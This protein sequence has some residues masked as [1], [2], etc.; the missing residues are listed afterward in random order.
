[1]C[2]LSFRLTGRIFL[3]LIRNSSLLKEIH[4]SDLLIEFSGDMFGE[5]I[6]LRRYVENCLKLYCAFLIGKKVVFFAGSP[7]PF[8]GVIKRTVSRLVFTH[9]ERILCRERISVIHLKSVGVP[10]EIIEPTALPL[11]VF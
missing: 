4:S 9:F 11:R 10:D 7:G 5:N 6:F 1:M 8:I 2:S 3:V